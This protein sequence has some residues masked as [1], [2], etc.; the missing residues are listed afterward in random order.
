MKIDAKFITDCLYRGYSQLS[1]DVISNIYFHDQFES[2]FIRVSKA[3]YIQEI[4]VKI[5]VSDFK[6]DFK[7]KYRYY[8]WRKKDYKAGNKHEE[9][10][11]GLTG[12][13]H[14]WFATPQGLIDH[15]IIPKYCGL[16]EID[17]RGVLR[18]VIRSP[19]LKD[20]IKITDTQ[21]NRINNKY[22]WAFLN[23]RRDSYS[24]TYSDTLKYFREEAN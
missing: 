14:F 6:A 11:S 12:L 18:E 15:S 23:L 19:Q 5:S 1:D 13:K 7:K 4:E 17:N 22:K 20:F 8:D 24:Q 2:D 21:Q 10:E 3:G 9:I 16:I